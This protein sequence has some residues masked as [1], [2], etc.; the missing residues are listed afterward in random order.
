VDTFKADR[1]AC[2]VFAGNDEVLDG[3]GKSL[4]NKFDQEPDLFKREKLYKDACLKIKD[5][6]GEQLCA[7]CPGFSAEIGA[8]LACGPKR[9]TAA[10][11]VCG[12]QDPAGALHPGTIIFYGETCQVGSV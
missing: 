4:G 8:G 2:S 10:K 9:G 3:D 1:A 11:P 7:Y 6:G 12:V 5:D